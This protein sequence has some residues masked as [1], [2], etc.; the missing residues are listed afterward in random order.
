VANARALRAA[1]DTTRY[2][3]LKK[4]RVTGP[5]TAAPNAATAAKVTVAMFVVV[6]VRQTLQHAGAIGATSAA[7]FVSDNRRTLVRSN[8]APKSCAAPY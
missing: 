6:Q 5:E 1:L 3:R 4:R 2:T 8:I 7:R